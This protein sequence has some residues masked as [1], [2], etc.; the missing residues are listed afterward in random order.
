MEEKIKTFNDLRRE[1]IEIGLCGKC[2]GC[3]SFCSAG[4]LNALEI[5]ENDF[6]E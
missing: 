4:E 3:Y 1:V 5:G 6:P 2:G